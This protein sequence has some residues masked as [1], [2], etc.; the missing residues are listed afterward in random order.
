MAVPFGPQAGGVAE[1]LAAALAEAARL[2]RIELARAP[3]ARWRAEIVRESVA[4]SVLY[5]RGAA[6]DPL[7]ALRLAMSEATEFE[8]IVKAQIPEA[9]RIGLP[10]PAPGGDPPPSGGGAAAGEEGGKWYC[11][12]KTLLGWSPEL[13]Y[14]RAPFNAAETWGP[15]EVKSMTG[16][17][18]VLRRVRKVPPEWGELSLAK[19]AA[20]FELIAPRDDPAER[21]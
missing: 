15:V 18:I 7:G 9:E 1:P 14:G 6:A 10:D 2:G 20:H 12:R 11:E 8:R 19:M 13:H 3:G 21:A 16:Q 5:A 17:R 4:G